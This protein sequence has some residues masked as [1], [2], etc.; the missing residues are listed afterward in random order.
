MAFSYTTSEVKLV[1]NI[2]FITAHGHTEGY[3]IPSSEVK[4]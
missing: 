2:G 3:I 4:V 1:S